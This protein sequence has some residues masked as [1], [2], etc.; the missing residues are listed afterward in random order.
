[1]ESP[2]LFHE[3]LRKL[4]TANAQSAAR[5]MFATASWTKI[6][7]KINSEGQEFTGLVQ[8]RCPEFGIVNKCGCN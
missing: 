6:P 1:M 7:K 8:R 4:A 5:A 2:L 3:S